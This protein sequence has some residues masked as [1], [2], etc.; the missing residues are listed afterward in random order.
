[1]ICSDCILSD[2]GSCEFLLLLVMFTSIDWLSCCINIHTY[3]YI[4]IYTN[5][6]L[7]IYFFIYWKLWVHTDIS[8]TI[9]L[10]WL[11][12]FHILT[13]SSHNKKLGSH[14]PSYT[15][16]LDQYMMN[17]PCLLPSVSCTN[18]LGSCWD[19]FSPYQNAPMWTFASPFSSS[20]ITHQAAPL[21]DHP[22]HM[23]WFL[24]LMQC[25]P[26]KMSSHPALVYHTPRSLFL[27]GP[28]LHCLME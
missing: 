13:S 12:S 24:H 16:I 11:L 28:I 23:L 10:F 3:A 9:G 17:L 20:N 2:D 6:H 7:Y 21:W 15:Y 14:Y 1:M 4:H 8:N 22:P 5:F 27:H 26:S 25:N 18:V 19:S